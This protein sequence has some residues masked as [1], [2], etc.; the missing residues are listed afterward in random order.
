MV[1]AEMLMEEG[2]ESGSRASENALGD[3]G[4][5][6]APLLLQCWAPVILRPIQP[7]QRQVST[8]KMMHI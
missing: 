8:L 2:E 5:S 3:A 1:T 4:A 7:R 6:G